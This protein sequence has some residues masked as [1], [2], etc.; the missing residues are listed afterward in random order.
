VAELATRLSRCP[1]LD[2]VVTATVNGLSDLLGYRHSSFLMLDEQ[3][4]ALYTIA[5][6]GFDVQGIGSEIVLGEGVVGMA[7]ARCEAVRVGQ[8]RQIQKYSAHRSPFVRERRHIDPAWRSRYP[9]WSMSRAALRSRAGARS[10]RRRAGG[11]EP[12]AGGV[13][14]RGRSGAAHD[15]ELGGQRRRARRAGDESTHR[16]APPAPVT[17]PVDATSLLVRFFPVD[18]SVFLDGDYLIRGVAGRILWSVLNQYQH[19]GRSSS[20]TRRC[21]SIRRSTFQAF[22]TT[23]TR[24]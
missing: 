22:A 7:A 6:H 2:A 15:R 3:G 11:R 23:S 20:P 13:R 12:D 4:K 18:G 1:D 21:G 19:D 17:E 9:N 5:S 8:L 16:S 24:A 10:T 14:R